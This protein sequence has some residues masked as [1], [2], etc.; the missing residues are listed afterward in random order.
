[1]K[2]HL[3]LMSSQSRVHACIRIRIRQWARALAIVSALL[4]PTWF[5]FW[6]PVHQEGQHV[7]TLD[8]KFEPLRQ[9]NRAS[10][11]FQQNIER[12]RAQETTALALAKIDTPV[13]TLLGMVS[14]AV[15]NTQGNVVLENL[16]F[17]QSATVLSQEETEE[18]ISVELQGRARDEFSIDQLAN[19]LRSALPFADLQISSSKPE[20]I[21]QQQM[22]I[23]TIQFS[24]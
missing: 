9:M 12:I 16:D 13:V 18:R 17:H 19:D 7:A 10:K 3:N 8:A 1:M 20:R 11:G 24:F 14:K 15:A 4:V 5:L 23:F 2:R 6:W 21:H 22:Q